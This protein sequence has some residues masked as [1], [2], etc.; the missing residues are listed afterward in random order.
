MYFGCFFHFYMLCSTQK[1]FNLKH[2][3]SFS[4]VTYLMKKIFSITFV[5]FCA[6]GAYAQGNDEVES[7]LSIDGP[8]TIELEGEDEKEI[9]EIP[10]KKKK[11][12]VF[13]GLK[14]KK[15]FTKKGYGNRQT[16]ELF[17][18]LKEF[19]LPETLVR[20]VYW[21]DYKRGEIRITTT[22]EVDQRNGAILHGPYTKEM[23]GVIVEEGIFFMGLKH[24]RWL[25]KNTEEILLDKSKYYKGWPKESLVKYYD[26]DR[27]Q[28]KEIIPVEYGEKEGNYF[29][30]HENGKVAVQGNYKW[31][32]RI[33]DWYEYY[34]SG[35]RKKA[36][37]YQKQPYSEIFTPYIL[38]EWNKKGK[39]VYQARNK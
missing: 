8:I 32:Q 12:N 2:N 5:I 7:I 18:V 34:P 27:N 31:D 35:L 29:Y 39:V 33:G 17:Y 15:R 21:Y 25:R 10:E 3:F 26:A 30:F 16:L 13:F 36:V 4:C 37:R 19:Q 38:T 23:N 14:T 22:R 11:K 1:I 9:Y 24:G 28:M 20:D 6:L